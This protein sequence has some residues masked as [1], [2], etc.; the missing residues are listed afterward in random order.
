MGL[1]GRNS[2]GNAPP[3]RRDTL[4]CAA[5][6][7]SVARHSHHQRFCSDRCRQDAAR[8]KA[9]DALK[10]SPRYPYSG[11]VTSDAKNPNNNKGLQRPK[12]GSSLFGNAPL[13]LLGGGSW[14]W[15]DPVYPDDKTLGNIL[16][17]EIGGRRIEAAS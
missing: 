2:E 9:V 13:N 4:K 12:S 7:R 15:S 14:R 3:K 5:C 11:P 17:C 8:R 1:H 16:R 10:K 6:G